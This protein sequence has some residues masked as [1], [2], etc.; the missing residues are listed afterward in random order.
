MAAFDMVVEADL[1][2]GVA[3]TSRDDGS[4]V[5]QIDWEPL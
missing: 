1:A 5:I 4:D 2:F 3:G